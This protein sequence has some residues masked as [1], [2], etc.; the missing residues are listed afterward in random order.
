MK[1]N[2][3]HFRIKA[4]V[5]ALVMLAGTLA[6]ATHISGR[7]NTASE[8]TN[9]RSKPKKK[10]SKPVKPKKMPDNKRI[11]VP[12]GSW[13]GRGASIVVEKSLVKFEFDCAQGE[14]REPFSTDSKGV[15]K[16]NGFYL[17]HPFGPT[18]ANNEPQFAPAVYKGFIKDKT[19][20]FAVAWNDTDPPIAE[21]AVESGKSA[22]LTRCK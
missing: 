22:R 5:L 14:I 1:I 21:Y 8:Q 19:M 3:S 7:T 2:P 17:R 20:T 9:T 16:V 18:L 10:P 11:M 6:A 15:F 4:I 13:G 12:A